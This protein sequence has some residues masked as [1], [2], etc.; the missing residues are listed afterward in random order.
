MKPLNS[1]ELAEFF[2]EYHALRLAK[3]TESDALAL[4]AEEPN[5]KTLQNFLAQL[6]AAPDLIQGLEQQH[7]P[8]YITELLKQHNDTQCFADIATH[9]NTLHD[10]GVSYQ[11][12]LFNQLLYPIAIISIALLLSAVMF[13]FVFPAFEQLFNSIGS[14]LPIITS[15]FLTIGHYAP[16]IL[17]LIIIL[18]IFSVYLRYN[19]TLKSKLL[20]NLPIIRTMV[21]N[22]ES[23]ATINALALLAKYNYSLTKAL[24]LIATACE[25]TVIQNSLNEA[26]KQVNE[27]STVNYL[28]QAQI[29]SEQTLR[30]LSLFSKTQSVLLLEQLSQ[31][32]QQ[33]TQLQQAR[34]LK[35][36][37]I[38][39]LLACWLFVGLMI[40]AL[41][42]PIFQ[43]GAAIG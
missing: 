14:E 18:L 13:I 43:L 24:P 30:V 31:S 9:L 10:K 22:I 19:I 6:I 11:R 25:N 36:L 42:L 23:I 15:T 3:Q 32:H 4:L 5:S 35:N 37:N 40:I 28:K 27:I 29:F 8:R 1:E 20:L 26:A 38:V 39:L 17:G 2:A 7:I 33:H 41:Y 12:Q 34:L 21:A 16:L